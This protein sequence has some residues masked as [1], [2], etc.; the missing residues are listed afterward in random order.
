MK[1][2]IYI[3]VE[4]LVDQLKDPYSWRVVKNLKELKLK[5]TQTKIVVK[6]NK[7][8][9]PSSSL[10]S[11]ELDNSSNQAEKRK[12]NYVCSAPTV[13]VGGRHE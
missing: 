13:H 4:G 9:K 1:G 8:V 5:F 2:D 12:R 6:E 11:A 3:L 10:V 7:S